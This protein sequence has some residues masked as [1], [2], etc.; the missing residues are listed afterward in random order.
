MRVLKCVGGD[1][2]SL[3]VCVYFFVGRTRE[4]QKRRQATF[5]STL[6]K[7]T[8]GFGSIDRR[9]CLNERKG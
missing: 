7:A 1:M 2:V 6:G 9:Y 8:I 5:T 4:A 3:C